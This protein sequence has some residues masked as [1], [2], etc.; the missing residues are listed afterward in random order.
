[1][2]AKDILC[3]AILPED[4]EKAVKKVWHNLGS[5]SQNSLLQE[6]MQVEENICQQS[7]FLALRRFLRT[8]G[9]RHISKNSIRT[10]SIIIHNQIIRLVLFP[11]NCGNLTVAQIVESPVFVSPTLWET[12]ENY[13]YFLFVFI[14]TAFNVILRT[15]LDKLVQKKNSKDDFHLKFDDH[16]M[17]ITAAVDRIEMAQKF[18]EISRGTRCLQVPY[19]L[20]DNVY[21]AVNKDLTPFVRVFDWH[22]V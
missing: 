18:K 21:G 11:I 6:I 7:V 8:H 15:E 9:I 3:L 16:R 22:G 20:G 14:D 13:D 19:G 2:R 12:R 10:N 4:V 1:M 5:Q 17:F